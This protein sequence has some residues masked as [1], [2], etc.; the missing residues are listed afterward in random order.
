MKTFNKFL[1][2]VN[3]ESPEPAK[4]DPSMKAKE[5]RQMQIKKLVLLKKMQAV[6][7]GAGSDIVASHTPDGEMVEDAKYGYDSKGNSL[8]PKDKK[9]GRHYRDQRELDRA[10]AF[11]KKNPNFG[12]KD[13]K[14]EDVP[15][16]PGG[17]PIRIKDKIKAAKGQIPNKIKEDKAFAVSYTHLTLPTIYSV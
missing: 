17:N 12:K 7:S 13:V 10:Q 1:E 6:R 11:I 4:E 9:K 15:R 16:G 5:K 2:E 3:P 14:E 8:N